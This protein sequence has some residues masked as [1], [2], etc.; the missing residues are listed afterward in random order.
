[1]L[2]KYNKMSPVSPDLAA[3]V[4]RAGTSILMITHG[5]P[6]FQKIL[7]GDFSFAD[8]IGI[9]EGP[10]LVMTA[11]AEFFC[12]VLLLLGLF[13]KPALIFLIF[14]MIVVIFMVH[15]NDPFSD[16]EHGISFLVPY[17]SLFLTGPGKFSLDHK[18]F[19]Q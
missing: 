16:K 10:S 1:M 17:I 11:F 12:S 9:G 13:T 3:L 8:P 19:K 7:N 18:L 15:G 6:K 14:T 2:K 5:Y 4:L